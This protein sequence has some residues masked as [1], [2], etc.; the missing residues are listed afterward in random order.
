[1][2]AESDDSRG[3]D[4]GALLYARLLYRGGFF[5]ALSGL[6]DLV[7]AETPPAPCCSLLAKSRSSGSSLMPWSLPAAR[8]RGNSCVRCLPRPYLHLHLCLLST[9]VTSVSMVQQGLLRTAVTR[10]SLSAAWLV[11]TLSRSAAPRLSAEEFLWTAARTH[12]WP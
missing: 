12:H 7:P 6:D 10:V 11:L 4:R 1:M 8:A 9:T 3:P 5:S 2:L